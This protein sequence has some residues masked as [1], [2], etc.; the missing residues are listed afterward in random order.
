MRYR[1]GRRGRGTVVAFEEVLKKV[2]NRVTNRIGAR[3]GIG[4]GHKGGV[5]AREARV[6]AVGEAG[7]GLAA[8]AS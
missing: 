3:I 8:A 6:G 1:R 7:V 4:V 2:D 5:E